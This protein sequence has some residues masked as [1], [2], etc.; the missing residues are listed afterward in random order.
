MID[1]FLIGSGLTNVLFV[2][3]TS[4]GILAPMDLLRVT[5]THRTTGP[6][7]R[8]FGREDGL[9]LVH[10]QTADIFKHQPHESRCD[11]VEDREKCKS[12]AST[13]WV[14]QGLRDQGKYQDP[15]EEYEVCPCNCRVNPNLADIREEKA[16]LARLE[17]YQEEK[18]EDK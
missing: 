9:L 10:A 16:A 14:E 18:E 5:I 6:N 7:T 15:A 2:S 3:S 13:K 11:Q 4:V 12:P 8:A 1:S 17:R